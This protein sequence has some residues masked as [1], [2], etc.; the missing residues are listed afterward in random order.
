ML[1]SHAQSA[2]KSRFR[3]NENLRGVMKHRVSFVLIVAMGFQLFGW[4]GCT[5]VGGNN[6]NSSL[7][8]NPIDGNQDTEAQTLRGLRS[9][10]PNGDFDRALEA[11]V[12][13]DRAELQGTVIAAG[14]IDVFALG[15][16]SA[17][18]RLIINASTPNSS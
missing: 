17:G 8:T 12:N 4:A 11:I 16:M 13:D 18:D 1:I 15:P 7:P 9:G 3:C 14:D 2:I 5:S 6:G 10:E